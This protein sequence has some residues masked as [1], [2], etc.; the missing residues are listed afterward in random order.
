MAL[1][2][3]LALTTVGAMAGA[4]VFNGG[5]SAASSGTLASTQQTVNTIN[6][7][8]PHIPTQGFSALTGAIG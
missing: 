8:A 4:G 7:T 5:G 6:S 2:G 3:Q 1:V